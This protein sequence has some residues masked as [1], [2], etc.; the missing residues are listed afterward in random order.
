MFVDEFLIAETT[1]RRTFH[2]PEPYAGNPVLQPETA[3]ELNGGEQ[4]VACPFS[5]GVFYDPTDRLFKLWYMAGWFD[6][7]ALAY[8]RDGLHWERP[9]FD[10]VPGTNRVIAPRPDFRRDGTGVWLDQ[11]AADPAERF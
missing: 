2:Q 3:L 5:D 8:S 10:V 1:L 4:P 6:G 7:T 11:E 9:A